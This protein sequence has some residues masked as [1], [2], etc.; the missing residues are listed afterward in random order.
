MQNKK[1]ALFLSCV[2]I[3]VTLQFCFL[4][5]P[6]HCLELQNSV[7]HLPVERNTQQTPFHTFNI[8]R[9]FAGTALTYK[10]LFANILPMYKILFAGYV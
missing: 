7:L 10:M 4:D 1:T 9:L 6:F 8:L 5:V 2:C 3:L